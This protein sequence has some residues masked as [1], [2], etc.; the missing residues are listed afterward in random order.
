MAN[1]VVYDAVTNKTINVIVAELTDTPP[2]G[3]Y[4]SELPTNAIWNGSE[5]ITIETITLTSQISTD[6]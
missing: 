1:C 3:C 6:L 4:L 2:A 5:L